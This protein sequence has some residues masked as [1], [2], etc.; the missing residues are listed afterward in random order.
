MENSV[1][2]DGSDCARLWNLW[3]LLLTEHK[4]WI[5]FGNGS[6]ASHIEPDV[7]QQWRKE[8][9]TNTFPTIGQHSEAKQMQVFARIPGLT[10]AL[11][12]LRRDPGFIPVSGSH[13]RGH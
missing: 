6:A 3:L 11:Q 1:V 8:I 9:T 5:K 2:I 13:T 4:T 7:A 10:R 12:R